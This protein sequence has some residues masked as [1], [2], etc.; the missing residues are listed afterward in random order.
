MEDIARDHQPPHGTDGVD[1]EA[2]ALHFRWRGIGDVQLDTQGKLRF[3][4]A[5]TEP[6]RVPL[7][8]GRR[9]GLGVL[10]R[11]WRSAPAIPAVRNADRTMRTNYRLRGKLTDVLTGGGRCGVSLAEVVSFEARSHATALDLR[12]KAAR[13]LIEGAAIVMARNDGLRVVL[14]LHKAFDRA[15][16]GD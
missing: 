2:V 15:L 11:G 5:D 10:R 14:N 8:G 7:R 12:S 13:V 16:G 1:D 6:R 4:R 9:R 3:P